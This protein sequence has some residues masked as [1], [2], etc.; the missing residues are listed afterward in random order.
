MKSRLGSAIAALSAFAAIGIVST[1]AHAQ[2]QGGMQ[3]GGMMQQVQIQQ[4]GVMMPAPGAPGPMPTAP[5]RP[6]TGEQ[7]TVFVHP[8]VP[9]LTSG[10][11]VFLGGY[12]PGFVVAATSDHDGDKWL[13]GPIIGPWGDLA[14]RGCDNNIQTATCGTTAW[15]RG[16]LIASGAVQA[17]GA[18]MM[19]GSFFTPQRKLVTTT[20]AVDKPQLLSVAPVSFDAHTPGVMAI[21][22]F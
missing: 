13:Y 1:Q 14:A 9:L 16:A 12:V 19:V 18:A 21:G 11:L 22:T 8:N 15:Q 6:P 20:G 2:Q 4:G 3:Q 7:K 17:V 10:A 5:Y